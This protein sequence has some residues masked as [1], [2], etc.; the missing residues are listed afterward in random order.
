VSGNK[1]DGKSMRAVPDVAALGDWNLGFQVG[2]TAQ[3]SSTKFQYVNAIYGGTSLAVQLFGGLEADLIQGRHGIP[4]GFF[5]P[6]LYD[7]A[8][9]PALR[10]ITAAPRDQSV[11][12]GPLFQNEPQLPTL[13]TMGECGGRPALP[14]GPGYDTATGLGSPGPEFFNSF[15]SHSY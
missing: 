12:I 1:I 13:S 6:A 9:T 11:V 7:M 5:N 15:G 14:C 4:L 10:D 2:L 8:G 3:I